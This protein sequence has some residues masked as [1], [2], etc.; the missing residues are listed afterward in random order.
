MDTFSTQP[1]L[2]ASVSNQAEARI[3]PTGNSAT[4]K[5]PTQST[6]F[7]T[8][9]LQSSESHWRL[10][11]ETKST[12]STMQPP[13][14]NEV[15]E[16]RQTSS[17]PSRSWRKSQNQRPK[18][19]Q[20]HQL[21]QQILTNM[22]EKNRYYKKF[23]II[24]ST[25]DQ[26]LAEIPTIKAYQ[27]LQNSIKGKPTKTTELRDGALLVEV[28]NEAQ[29]H[30]ILNIKSLAGTEVTVEPHS[31]LNQIKGTIRYHNKPKYSIEEIRESLKDQKVSDIYQIKRKNGNSLESTNIFIVTFD[32]CH[33]PEK[34]WIGWTDCD[35]REYIPRPRR[36]YKCQGFG[37]A[38]TRCRGE[39]ICFR[40]G[41]GFHEGLCEGEPKC[42]NCEGDHPAT[43]K[44]CFYYKLEQETLI[45]QTRNR[46]SY[47]EAK[48]A[49]KQKYAKP[50]ATYSSV[51]QST[52]KPTNNPRPN[53]QKPENKS[54]PAKEQT[55]QSSTKEQHQQISTKEQT[56]PT[57]FK[58]LIQHTSTEKQTPP[59]EQSLPGEQIPPKE[60]SPP[61][62]QTPSKKQT[63]PKEQ[64]QP[65]TP[66]K[67]QFT[68]PTLPKT[69]D[70]HQSGTNITSPKTTLEKPPKNSD[71]VAKPI[72]TLVTSGNYGGGKRPNE[73]G[74]RGDESV[75]KKHSLDNPF[76]L[77]SPTPSPSRF[78]G[79]VGDP[80]VNAQRTSRSPQ[81]T[82]PTNPRG[83][84]SS[85]KKLDP[86]DPMYE[87]Y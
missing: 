1:N 11:D 12:S 79:S 39:E 62:E 31:S 47:G 8:G 14:E 24:K 25:N 52:Q 55:K 64:I 19:H 71:Q 41:M 2:V 57:L 61:K 59:E 3:T 82:T 20:I 74:D 63:P 70:K 65:T 73:N 45:L 72:G 13:R 83:S 27:E 44:D 4:D 42:A 77:R 69:S 35:V 6:P 40:C 28:A 60:Q 85:S 18:L 80:R 67:N 21:N 66:A 84:R 36:C 22:Y 50:V 56:P 68:T 16:K 9:T 49:V 75:K 86:P 87:D 38:K 7:S 43:S 81:R 10:P 46:I 34:I 33:L 17:Q 29:S 76:T 51:L 30:N 15:K 23:F 53:R 58:E 37:H 54:S 5:D 48:R 32:A 78:T 26:N